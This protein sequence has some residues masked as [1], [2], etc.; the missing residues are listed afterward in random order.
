[1]SGVGDVLFLNNIKAE[2]A[3]IC[4]SCVKHFAFS[5][6]WIIQSKKIKI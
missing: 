1:M 5:G 2:A 6:F 3:Y 4:N